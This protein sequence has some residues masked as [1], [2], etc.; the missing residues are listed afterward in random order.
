[1]IVTLMNTSIKTNT[2]M[3]LSNYI[4]TLDKSEPRADKAILSSFYTMFCV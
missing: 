1:M 2:C 3:T 4:L